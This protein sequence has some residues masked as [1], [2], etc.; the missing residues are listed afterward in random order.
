MCGI[1]GI[2][3]LGDAPPPSTELCTRMMGR[4]YHRGPDSS[5]YY[6]DRWVA[7]GHTRLA[8]IDLESGAQPLSNE[9][10]S[11]WITLNGEIY[12]YLELAE[13]LKAL[14]HMFRTKSDTEVVIHAYEQWHTD[15]FQRFNGQWALAIWDRRRATLLLS[16]DRLGIRPLYYTI[17]NGRLMFASEIKAIFADPSVPRELDPAGL[18]ETYTFWGPVAPRTAFR[19]IRELKPGHY[20]TLANGNLT[21]RPF[22]SISFPEAGSEPSQNE[23]ENAEH[24]RRQLI[25]AARLRFLRSDVPVGAYI[26]GGIDSSVTSAIVTRYTEAPLH[27]FSIRF[28]DSEFDEGGYQRQIVDRLGTLHQDVLVSHEDIGRTFPD[29]I[30]HAERPILRTAPAPLFLLSKLVRK[31]GYKVVVTGEGADEVLG[32]YDI[33]REAKA[34]LFLSRD[35]SSDKRAQVLLSLYPWM[36]RSPART[37]AFARAFFGKSLDPSD[38]GFSHRP[39]WNTSA[40]ILNLLDSNLKEEIGNA[41]ISQELLSRLPP[42]FPKWDSLGRAQWLEMTT[43]LAG[44]ILSAQGDRMLMAH[45]VEGRFPFLDCCLVD[46][47]N[48]LPA[49]HKLLALDEKH[50]LKTACGDLVPRSILERPKQPYRAPDANSFFAASSPEWLDELT[51]EENLRKARIFNPK[52]VSGLIAK[53]RRMEGKKMSNTD[54]MR[55]VAVLSTLLLHHHYVD[56]DSNLREERQPPKPMTIID[57]IAGVP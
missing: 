40:S 17:S 42:S 20:A 53:C 31:S 55:I 21:S 49:R 35:P 44:Y 5:G 43:L 47:S 51:G 38:P 27:T 16:R 26:S 15:C 4:L 8:I 37:P 25:E 46:F 2:V 12:N 41:E 7:L 57:K 3:N 22:W 48:A 10:D 34:R 32:G 1:C 54:N 13:E 19:E 29:V 9:D 56:T 36:A 45:S 24:L 6:R 39:R 33:Y 50:I 23:E 52:A 30:R 11:M 14:G 28:E 18:A